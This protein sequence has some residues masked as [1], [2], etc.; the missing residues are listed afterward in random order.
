MF[1]EVAFP[2]RGFKTFTYSIPQQLTE[3][4]KIGSRVNVSFGF[5][6]TIGIVTKIKKETSFDGKIKDIIKLWN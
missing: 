1:V 6:K 5:R 3:S 2:I 4:L